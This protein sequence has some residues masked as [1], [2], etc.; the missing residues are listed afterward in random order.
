MHAF[1]SAR[2]ESTGAETEIT[3]GRTKVWA[4]RRVWS[5]SWQQLIEHAIISVM[6]CPQS[7]R[8]L[9]PVGV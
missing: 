2:A 7:I 4:A 6:S 9:C 8:E 1:S 3:E 5:E